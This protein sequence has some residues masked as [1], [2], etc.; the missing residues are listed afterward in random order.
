M[1]KNILSLI[2]QK[3]ENKE[4]IIFWKNK[5]NLSYCIEELKIKKEIYSNLSL[6]G[7]N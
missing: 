7:D 1:F 4:T 5:G 6:K 2:F 3:N